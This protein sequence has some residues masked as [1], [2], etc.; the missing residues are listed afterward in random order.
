M[1]ENMIYDPCFEVPGRSKQVVCGANPV[2]HE[3][4]FSLMLTEPLPSQPPGNTRPQPWL[5]ELADGSV[6]EAATGTMAV[7]EGAPVRYPCSYPALKESKAPRIYG[8]LGT[9]HPAK[10]WTADKVY[11]TVVPSEVGPPFELKKRE[12]VEVRRV[13]E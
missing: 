6:C 5:I 7:I 9:L 10:V 8:L 2:K 3:D 13:W 1:R 11:F 4:G 12:T